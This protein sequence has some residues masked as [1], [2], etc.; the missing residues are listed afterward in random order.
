MCTYTH[1]H[2][3]KSKANTRPKNTKMKARGL[4][5]YYLA[6][7]RVSDDAETSLGTNITRLAEETRSDCLSDKYSRHFPFNTGAF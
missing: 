4:T 1:T 2:T 3:T 5:S 6:N 7:S